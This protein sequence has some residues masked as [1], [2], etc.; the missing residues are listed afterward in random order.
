[1]HTHTLSGSAIAIVVST[2]SSPLLLLLYTRFCNLHRKTWGGWSF[3]G[4]RGWGPFIRLGVPGLLMLCFEWWSYELAA[5]VVGSINRTQLGIH[6]I[7]MQ[8]L[9]LNYMVSIYIVRPDDVIVR[10]HVIVM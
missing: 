9:S 6:T 5:F 10:C 2:I 4:L 7:L 8:I 1:M 3:E